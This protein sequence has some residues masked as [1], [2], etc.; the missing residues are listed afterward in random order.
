MLSE[1]QCH[2]SLALS[3]CVPRRATGEPAER[4]ARRVG[5]RAQ[6]G[7]QPQA[8]IKGGPVRSI[9]PVKGISCPPAPRPLREGGR[10]RPG[11][12]QA[13]R[14]RVLDTFWK[15]RGL[16]RAEGRENAASSS[17]LGCIRE[18]QCSRLLAPSLPIPRLLPVPLL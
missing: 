3:G 2:A 7:A 17:P 16:E 14:S 18:P 15:K 13:H 10:H 6:R 1:N 9:S 4:G 12:V 8:H 11:G 5:S